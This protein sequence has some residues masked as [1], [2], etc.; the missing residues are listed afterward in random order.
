MVSMVYR[1]SILLIQSCRRADEEQRFAH[2]DQNCCYEGQCSVTVHTRLLVLSRTRQDCGL[3]RWTMCFIHG[4]RT[5]HPKCGE[6]HPYGNRPMSMSSQCEDV[7]CAAMYRH[8][9]LFFGQGCPQF[10]EPGEKQL[11]NR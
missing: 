9:I 11:E 6:F 8:S 1:N 2:R 10:L 4:S 7:G 5:F 3:R